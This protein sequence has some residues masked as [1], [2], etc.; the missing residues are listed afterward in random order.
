MRRFRYIL[1]RGDMGKGKVCLKAMQAARA[2]DMSGDSKISE[3]EFQRICSP[4]V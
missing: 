3:H 1:G 4:Y 2:L